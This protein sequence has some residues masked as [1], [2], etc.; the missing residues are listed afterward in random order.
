MSGWTIY[1]KNGV[2]KYTVKELE[3]HDTWMGEEYVT[4][5]IT[6]PTPLDIEIGDYLIYRGLTYSVYSVP[7]ALKQARRGSYGEAFKYDNIKL[8]S[9]GVELTDLRFLDYVLEDNNIHYT[10]L[11]TFSFHC[12]TVDDLLD[13]LQANTDRDGGNQWYFIS[14]SYSRTMQRYQQGTAAYTE[15]ARLWDEHFGGD[16]GV[17]PSYERTDVNI[18]IDKQSVWDGLIHIKNDFNLNFIMRERAVI[19]G[20]EGLAVGHMFRYGKGNGLYQIER[21]ADQDQK[22]TTKLF[23]YGSDKNLPIR[24]YANITRICFA[25]MYARPSADSKTLYLNLVWSRSYVTGTAD[26]NGKY[27]VVVS[28]NGNTYNVKA[29]PY[30]VGARELFTIDASV[31]L[32]FVTSNTDIIFVSGIDKDK[33]PA[34]NTRQMSGGMPNN[35]AVQ[36]L[37]LPG[38]PQYALSE[39]CRCT[40]DSV[41]DKTVYEI[42]KTPSSAYNEFMRVD[43]NH[44][45]TFSN[46]ALK[47]YILS[48]NADDLGIKEGDVH[49]TEDNDDNG[50]KE[51][52]P[53][54]EGMTRGDVEGTSS[55]ERLDEIVSCDV[56]RDNGVFTDGVEIENF[57]LVLKNI[58]FDLKEAFDN[59]GGNMTISMKDGYCG[60]RDFNVHS[61]KANANGTWT[62]NVERSHDESLD[63][64]FP[65]STN[66]A[67]GQTPVADEPYQIRTGD[68][69]VLT[70]IE[71]GDTSYIWAAAMKMLRKSIIW[72]LDNDYTR[73]T[74]LPKVD[75]IYMARQ[76]DLSDGITE[77][78]LHDTLKS[79]MVML[80]EDEDLGVDGSVFIDSVTIKENGNNGIPTYDVVLR[81]D[82]QV[83]TMQ[84][85]QNQIQSLTSYVSGGGGGLTPTQIRSLINT[86]GAERF[87]SKLNDDTAQG[88]IRFMQGLQVGNQFVS[89]ILGEGGVF[90]K[91]ADGKTY[92]EADK[93][94]IRMKAYFDSVEIR[95]YQHT[96]GN[97]IASQAKGFTASRV[98]WLDADGNIT[99]N[100]ND[101]VKFRCYWRAKDDEHEAENQFVV[102]DQAFMEYSDIV[103]GS[104]IQKRFWRVVTGRNVSL[105]EDGEAWIDLSNKENDTITYIDHQGTS[106]TKS[107]TGCEAVAASE[108]NLSSI[109]QAEDDICQLGNVWDTSR[110][111]AI[112]EF[113]SGED[114]PSYQIFQGID[115]FSLDGRNYISLGYS[116]LTGNAYINVYGDAYIGDKAGKAGEG[117][118]MSFNQQQRLL[119]IKGRLN[120][121]STLS[122]GRDVNALGVNRGNL[123]LNT[124]FTG[125]YDSEEVNSDTSVDS[126]TVMYSDPLRHWTANNVTIVPFLQSSSKYAATISTGGSLAQDVSLENGKWYMLSFRGKGGS[127]GYAIGGVSGTLQLK[128][129]L[130]TYD[131]PF[132]CGDSESGLTITASSE[133][134]LMELRLNEGNL[135]M[136]W[137]QNYND[138]NRVMAS[139]NAYK[140][141]SDA[142]RNASTDI[143]GGLI[144]SQIIKVGNYRDKVMTE[145]TGGMS[146]AY[147]DDNSPFLW[148]G[149]D[150]SDAIY[151]IM[152]YADNPSYEA[153]EEEISQMAHF[154]VTHGG[155]AILN[156]V[157]LR[158]YIYALG[159]Y[160]R[161]KITAESGE[162]TGDVIVG[163][164]DK[165]YFIIS[166]SNQYESAIKAFVKQNGVERLMFQIDFGYEQ[167]FGYFPKIRVEKGNNVYSQI[168]GGIIETRSGDYGV[169]NLSGNGL[170]T[171]QFEGTCFARFGFDEGKISLFAVKLNDGEPQQQIHA[172]KT[173][174]DNPSLGE[175]Y[176][177]GEGFLKV[178]LK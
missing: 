134:T 87:L 85:I 95:E 142:I 47:P 69:F 49:F 178:K 71:I 114:A 139:V 105:T 53:S 90:R 65:Y 77:H 120:V 138:G 141:I 13:R 122:D 20:G 75:E 23:A 144:L 41:N 159:G 22:V 79:G 70:E 125:D 108:E 6:S 38:F 99:D 124:S 57:N 92:I 61:V 143:I 21:V 110:Q 121:G 34:S 104:L 135:P 83:G 111:G 88:F 11:P 151:T 154:V 5:S 48:G 166:P 116:S 109:P 102:G 62:L 169:S 131:V 150:I 17:E 146:G 93:M 123:L 140:Y 171:Q 32:S 148:G 28:I 177:N 101:V 9:R 39:L 145:E 50:L 163:D 4:V 107:V 98:E 30:T 157:I 74:Y 63:L 76:H 97:R 162:I 19:V 84:R 1:S 16:H 66:A 25:K 137:S 67:I 37:M 153:T 147:L 15:A 42:R 73:F 36:V 112:I 2:A 26:S 113:V 168:S 12:M 172:W 165:A 80:F 161:G 96:S 14:P 149:G 27:P 106:R 51:I 117:G 136:S 45:V 118:Y 156:D 78:S 155:R 100:I 126:D 103:D 152:K 18:S 82:K 170:T 59:A 43:S 3:F 60:G 54:I 52:Y 24:Y 160:F 132:V 127:I 10:S 91:D 64:W 72:L 167:G 176:V 94:Y 174:A 119:E 115:T 81:N 40:Y 128:E 175:V 130:D 8:S 164:K 46:D 55:T 133:V 129:T 58:G 29:Y 68:H 35:M 173:S 89:G 7:S 31:S 44:P 86:Y 158:G 56:I 33:F